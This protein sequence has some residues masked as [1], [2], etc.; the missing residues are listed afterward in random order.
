MLVLGT[1]VAIPIVSDFAAQAS[2]S[3]AEET[4]TVL[5]ESWVVDG[6]DVVYVEAGGTPCE[7]EY[8]WEWL[9]MNQPDCATA[10]VTVEISENLFGDA[11][12]R[13]ETSVTTGAVTSVLVES[14]ADDGDYADITSINCD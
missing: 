6:V 12:R 8:C 3:F 5:S 14:E 10:T 1:L 13:V 9:L 4:G 7:N 2:A 11:Q